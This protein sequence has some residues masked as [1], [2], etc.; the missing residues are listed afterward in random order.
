MSM[1]ETW[2]T[3]LYW[4]EVGGLLVE[5]FV[6]VK[7]GIN[8]GRRLVDGLIVLGEEKAIHNSNYF[9]IKGRDVIVIQTKAPR[10]GMYLL[11][12]AYFSKSLI[13][14]HKPRSIKTVAICGRN[15]EVMAELAAEHGIEIVVIA[16]DKEE[17]IES[18]AETLRRERH[19]AIWG[20]GAREAGAKEAKIKAQYIKKMLIEYFDTEEKVKASYRSIG[21]SFRNKTGL[22]ELIIK[23]TDRLTNSNRTGRAYRFLNDDKDYFRALKE[24]L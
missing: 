16:D 20:P 9:D 4:N 1:H 10:I 5:E 8:H 12:Q 17:K 11:G 18:S 3:R 21:Q 22:H 13:E 19:D 14:K 2:R 6:A 15:D 24:I 7:S 23:K